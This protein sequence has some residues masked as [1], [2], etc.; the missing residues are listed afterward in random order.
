MLLS[1]VLIHSSAR[2]PIDWIE[3]LL[4]VDSSPHTWLLI[5]LVMC[6]WFSF[7]QSSQ[8]PPVDI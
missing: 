3:A 1:K 7:D 6:P 5:K 4:L 2:R 8:S